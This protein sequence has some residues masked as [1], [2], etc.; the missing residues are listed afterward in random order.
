MQQTALKN[1]IIIK[2]YESISGNNSDFTSEQQML[3]L[4]L[5]IIGLGYL[6]TILQDIIKELNF[7]TLTADIIETLIV[8]V[9]YY[10]SRL[11]RKT[12]FTTFI[13]IISLF[14]SF[15][16]E[17]F[18]NGGLNGCILL[19]Y[20]PLL[21]Y[22]IFLTE[23]KKQKFLLITLLI[24]ITIL[25]L[26]EYYNP[27]LV[28]PYGKRWMQFED[29]YTAFLCC[30]IALSYIVYISKRLYQQEK[31]NTIDVIEQY[32]KNSENLQ[33]TYN[34]KTSLLSGREREVFKL[35]IEGKTNKEIAS[36]LNIEERTVK[37]H[38]TS[39]YK[40]VEVKSRIEIINQL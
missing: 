23:G 38:I 25:L 13:L 31:K 28:N 12:N 10:F 22:I 18:P 24:N 8:I 35:I 14:I 34:E 33:K 27:K 26:I 1:N 17:W 36:Q 7:F 20:L 19:Y 29:M 16:I 5:F 15:S 2:P 4:S 40:K 9:L 37:N 39:I 21:A 11:K 32:R 6:F 30:L 3:N